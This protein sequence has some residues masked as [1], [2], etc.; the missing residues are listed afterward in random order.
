MCTKR[1]A[2]TCKEWPKPC[3]P[4]TSQLPNDG[5]MHQRSPPTAPLLHMFMSLAVWVAA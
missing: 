4:T 2:A 5:I 1:L 3:P